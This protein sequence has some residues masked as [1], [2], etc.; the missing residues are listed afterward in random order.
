MTTGRMLPT[1]ALTALLTS[2]MF[3]A[4]ALA[5]PEG[6]VTTQRDGDRVVRE[7]RLEGRLYAIEIIESGE[8]TVLLDTDGDGNFRRLSSEADITPPSWTQESAR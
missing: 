2:A 3:A 6:E 4:T 7:Y 1:L 5:G 8:R